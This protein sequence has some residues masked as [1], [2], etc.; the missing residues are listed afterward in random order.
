MNTKSEQ[1]ERAGAT[2][3]DAQH[4]EYLELA[5]R[6]MRVGPHPDEAIA[7]EAAAAIRALLA[8]NPSPAIADDSPALQRLVVEYSEGDGCTYN[9]RVT[10]AV[11]YASA[12]AFAVDFEAACRNNRKAGDFKF[13]GCKFDAQCFFEEDGEYYG[14]TVMTVDYWYTR[15]D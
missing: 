4:A 3:T 10:K 14:P 6:L 9:C 15:K 5:G 2:L 8:V 13:A 12:Q 11:R 7:M 1:G